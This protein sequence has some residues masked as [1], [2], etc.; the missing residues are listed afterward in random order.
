MTDSGDANRLPAI[1]CPELGALSLKL[2]PELVPAQQSRG[3]RDRHGLGP[4]RIRLIRRSLWLEY[5]LARRGTAA[6]LRA[7]QQ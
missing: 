2:V 6:A 5:L 3:R 7:K 1:S 4:S